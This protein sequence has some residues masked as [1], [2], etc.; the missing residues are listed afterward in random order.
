VARHDEAPDGRSLETLGAA[1]CRTLLADAG[2]GRL[3]HTSGA[4]PA[5]SPVRFAVRDGSLV[6]PAAAG[7]PV[8]AAGRG[9]VVAVQADCF[10]AATGSGWSVTAVGTAHLVRD[11]AELARLAATAPEP[12][13]PGRSRAYVSVDLGVLTGTRVRPAAGAVPEESR[14]TAG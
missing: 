8:A 7:S 2:V 12:W 10:D 11:P 13:A 4:L 1:E 9:T 3:A 14:A 6:I 5:I